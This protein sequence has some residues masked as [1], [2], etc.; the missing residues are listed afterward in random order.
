M[1]GRSGGEVGRMHCRCSILEKAGAVAV[2]VFEYK[3]NAEL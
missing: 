1:N 3:L 2:D